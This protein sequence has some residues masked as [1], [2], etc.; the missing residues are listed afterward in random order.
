MT[1]MNQKNTICQ[2]P[3][4]HQLQPSSA[5]QPSISPVSSNTLGKTGIQLQN[6]TNTSICKQIMNLFKIKSKQQQKKGSF[7]IKEK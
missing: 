6:N 2:H 7:N 3:R 1:L 5:L 4:Q